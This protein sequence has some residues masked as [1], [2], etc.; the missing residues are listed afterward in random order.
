MFRLGIPKDETPSF[1][2]HSATRKNSPARELDERFVRILKI[3]KWGPDAE[4]ALEVLKLKVDHRLVREVLQV[5]VEINVKVQ[6]FRWAGKRR[7]FEHDCTTYMAL[8]RCLEEARLVGGMWKMIQE[9]AKSSCAIGPS[10]LSDIVR[11]LGKA[12]MVNKAL[13]VFYQIKNRKCKPTA[14]TYN[15]MIFT[16]M[17]EGHYE[18]VHELYN[19][20]CSE[21]NCFPDTVTYSA[22]ISTF[23]KL[24]RGD[25]AIRLF[26]EMKAN[27]LC[28]TQK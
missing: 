7:N 9:M 3:F 19:E 2:N 24:G 6:F 4:K 21:G 20:M 5:D 18:K 16:L 10:D 11:I 26:E 13:S 17:Q 15:S 14:A 8:I 28:P 12:K 27:G 23:G 25:S 22:L 1:G